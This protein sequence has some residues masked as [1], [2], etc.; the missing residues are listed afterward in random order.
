VSGAHWQGA[1][2]LV[3]GARSFIGT[4]LC[5]RLIDAGAVVHG[6]SRVPNGVDSPRMHFVGADLSQ[7]ADLRRIVGT[8]EPD[9]VFHLAGHVT[10]S[11]Q[12]ST[13]AP[14]F[15][16]NLASTV[17]LLTIAAER[18]LSRVVLA[19]SM[20]EPDEARGEKIPSSP[21]AASKWACT[22]YAAMFHALYQLPVVIAR[23]MLVYG[24]GQ[25]DRSKLLPFVVESMLKGEA[26]RLT[27]GTREMDWVFID[28]V[29][30]GLMTLAATAGI[31]G[32]TIDLGTGHLI[33][34]KA[35]VEEI[36]TI[37]GSNVAPL[38]GAIPDRPFEFARA[39]SAEETRRLTGWAAT[40]PLTAGLRRTI[41]WHRATLDA[42]PD[43]M[44][45]RH[46]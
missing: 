6:V 36:R 3:T 25:W 44:T 8:A 28:D 15:E 33:T 19:G 29:V 7:G 16:S 35:V 13:V 26:P 32:R 10:G 42:R 1:R 23:P 11:Q 45:D 5:Q 20:T 14:T 46:V 21:Y 9:V 34:I 30:G 2:V 38:F 18:R 41:D 12:I 24:P 22:A 39:A 40:T 37:I 43:A 4:R 31:D 17:T 27:S